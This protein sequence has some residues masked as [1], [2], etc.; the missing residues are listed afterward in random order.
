MCVDFFG[1]LYGYGDGA[2]GCLGL[3]DDGKRVA[4]IPISFFESKRR[5]IHVAAGDKFTVVIAEVQ[6]DDDFTE[7][8]KEVQIEKKTQVSEMWCKVGKG[9]YTMK[10][11]PLFA[12]Q[13]DISEDV[14]QQ[15]SRVVSLSR[16]QKQ[17]Y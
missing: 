16:L 5:A 14:K 2:F 7:V 13:K 17:L 4:L 15:I 12:Y 11:K 6:P 9:V 1:R 10:S 8:N 3:G